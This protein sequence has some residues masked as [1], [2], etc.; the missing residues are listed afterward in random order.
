MKKLIFIFLTV[1]LL[2]FD[3]AYSQDNS[4]KKVEGEAIKEVIEEVIKICK[5]ECRIVNTPRFCKRICEK[6]IFDPR[7]KFLG[8]SDD[9][10]AYFYDSKSIF[11]SDGII[12]VWGKL[13]YSEKGKQDLIK[14]KGYKV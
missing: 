10:S 7:W 8:F 14:K 3:Y 13:I 6:E 5:E 12:K 11:I 9:G 2:C 1:L 4:L